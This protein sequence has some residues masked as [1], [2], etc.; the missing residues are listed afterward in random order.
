M[1]RISSTTG[2]S[3]FPL[4]PIASW[5]QTEVMRAQ[6]SF[7]IAIFLWAIASQNRYALAQPSD[8]AKGTGANIE[9]SA[10]YLSQ[11]D[12][13]LTIRRVAIL[14]VLDNLEGIYARPIEAQLI[15][16][17]KSSHRWDFVESGIAG[18]T[19][20]LIELEENPTEVQRIT[21]SV[22]ADAFLAAAASRGPNGL[23]IRLDL[24]LKKDG[25]ILSQELLRNHS[26]YE[27][28]EVREQVNQLYRRL[29]GRIP[30]Q[31][32][33]LS[34]Q[35]NRV[36]INLGK[37]DGI[38]KDQTVT[39]I[40]IIGVNRHPKFGF[41]VSTDKEI[42][43]RI[44]I[45]KVDETLS[46]GAIV[47]EKERGAIRKLAKVAGLEQVVYPEPARLEE[48]AASGDVASRPDA[49]VTFGKEPKEW[50]PVRPPSFGQVGMKLGF[51]M[52]SS[53]VNLGSAGAL[54]AKS[55]LYPNIGMHG[56]L[57]LT[58][59]W[60][61][62]AE[63][64]QGVISTNNPRSGSSPGSLNHALSRYSLEFGYN[65]LL[66]NDFF[67]PKL[68]LSAGYS[69][70]RMYVD[71]SSPR[72]LTTANY[73]GM[74][75][76]LGGSFPVTENK[77][78]YLSGKLNYYLIASLEETPVTSGGSSKSSINDFN[79]SVERKIAENFRVIGSLDF[80]LYTTNFSGQGTRTNG[81]AAESA[82]TMSHDHKT[83]TGGLIYMF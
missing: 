27:L 12:E 11:L 43:G 53:S 23:S 51:G 38:S 73:S 81:G 3:V 83:I 31:G 20:T 25:K 14:P 69:S 32:L 56:E 61:A 34:R 18:A 22:E 29:V 9:Q 17:L 63:L 55:A 60:T 65:F 36:T 82:T 71:D 58:P 79:L 57:W 72:A 5:W 47:S 70:Y 6:K 33:V 75:I 4:E 40:Q 68:S 67:G 24:F 16:L 52:Y 54:E 64:M 42:L 78:W 59:E 48:G 1:P 2:P 80:S 77:L 50:L 46:F 30:Y 21:R 7:I 39:A 10:T 45:L 26:R 35:Q 28:P 37:S 76:G 49:A 62:R 44:K 8:S 41:L 19:P 74:L 15:Q 13:D 66:R